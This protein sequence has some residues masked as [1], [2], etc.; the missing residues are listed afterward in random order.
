MKI[1]WGTGIAI[2]LTLF[3]LFILGLVYLTSTAD[4]DLVAPDY[5][6]Q[7]LAFQER[8]DA[9]ANGRPLGETLSLS[10]VDDRIVI[11]CDNQVF[12]ASE[13][14]K[15]SFY[16]PDD[17]A[18]DVEMDLD[19]AAGDQEIDATDLVSG[20]YK[21]RFTWSTESGDYEIN[22]ELHFKR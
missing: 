12:P 22:R 13:S 3:V 10:V 19:L 20:V 2:V 18:K 14:G 15:I 6:K 11:T 7:E 4:G 16:R 9:V 21:V 17:P 1:N 8:I 5:Y